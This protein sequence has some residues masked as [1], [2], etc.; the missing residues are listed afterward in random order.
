MDCWRTVR[1]VSGDRKGNMT[2]V[3]WAQRAQPRC[4]YRPGGWPQCRRL[5]RALLGPQRLTMLNA[6]QWL[7]WVALRRAAAHPH[8]M[9]S[10][11]CD[12]QQIA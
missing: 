5:W 12:S 3:K 11:W 4:G 7:G 1:P 10:F 6:S 9:P 8:G 2:Q